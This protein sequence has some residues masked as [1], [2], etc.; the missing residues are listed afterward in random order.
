MNGLG[1]DVGR[2]YRR[3][4]QRVIGWPVPVNANLP[5]VTTTLSPRRGWKTRPVA[6]GRNFTFAVSPATTPFNTTLFER[7][8]AT[9]VPSYGLLFAVM[10]DVMLTPGAVML[11][12]RWSRTQCVVGRRTPRQANPLTVTPMPVPHSHS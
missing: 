7:I 2:Q 11:A 3:L 5:T 6:V 4:R 10:P 1:R 12:A 9:V 8:V